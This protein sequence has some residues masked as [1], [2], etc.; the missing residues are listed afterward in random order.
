MLTQHANPAP[1][2]RDTTHDVLKHNAVLSICKYEKHDQFFTDNI[3]KM[4]NIAN[5]YI[6]SQKHTQVADLTT[7]TRRA[8][9]SFLRDGQKVKV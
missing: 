7:V 4:C 8:F 5:M 3:K 6:R 9:C 2:L 1:V